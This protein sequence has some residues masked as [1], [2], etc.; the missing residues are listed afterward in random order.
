MHHNPQTIKKIAYAEGWKFLCHQTD[1]LMLSFTK[2]GMRINVWYT[3]MTVSTALNHPK[4]GKTQLYR[5]RVGL[6]LLKAIF[7]NPR[8]H[9]FIGYYNSRY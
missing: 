3:K 1:N 7:K 8:V 5:Q 4:H 9:T 6:G 2:D